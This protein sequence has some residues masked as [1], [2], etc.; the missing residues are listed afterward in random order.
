[1]SNDFERFPIGEARANLSEIVGKVRFGKK[2]IILR[3]RAKEVAVIV[4]IEYLALI[5]KKFLEG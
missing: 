2:P 4:P 1:M 3:S 5:E